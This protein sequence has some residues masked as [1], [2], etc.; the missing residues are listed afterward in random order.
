MQS[1]NISS[2]ITSILNNIK[3]I[4]SCYHCQNNNTQY[5]TSR[6]EIYCHDCGS[7]LSQC[8][9][10]YTPNLGIFQPTNKSKNRNKILKNKNQGRIA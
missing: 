3:G 5:D 2:T 9:T 10:D 6:Y 4:N 7:V 1:K 8:L